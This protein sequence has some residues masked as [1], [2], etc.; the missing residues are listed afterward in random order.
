MVR[1]AA[2]VIGLLTTVMW[3]VF[4]LAISKPLPPVG[5]LTNVLAVIMG[6]FLGL[7]VYVSMMRG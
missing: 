1:L 6:P 4:W 7:L 2:Q 3:W 5:T